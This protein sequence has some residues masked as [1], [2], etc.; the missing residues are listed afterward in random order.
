MLYQKKSVKGIIIIKYGEKGEKRE[1]NLR[2]EEIPE[3]FNDLDN[4][5][6]YPWDNQQNSY[7]EIKFEDLP[8]KK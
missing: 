3:K 7:R 5:I 1:E 8:H 4:L 2:I 6:S